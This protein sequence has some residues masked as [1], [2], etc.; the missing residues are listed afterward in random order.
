MLNAKSRSAHTQA[1]LMTST[2]RLFRPFLGNFNRDIK[3]RL[4]GDLVGRL[5]R[6]RK[7]ALS[8]DHILALVM[9]DVLK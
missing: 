8:S 2:K 9:A 4:R 7:L 3:P 6:W 1:T 5:V